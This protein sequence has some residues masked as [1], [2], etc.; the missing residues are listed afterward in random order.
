M[1]QAPSHDDS[2]VNGINLHFTVRLV[3]DVIQLSQVTST[4]EYATP[5][6]PRAAEE[7]APLLID[8]GQ[9]LSRSMKERLVGL[10]TGTALQVSGDGI[11][12]DPPHNDKKPMDFVERYSDLLAIVGYASA[13]ECVSFRF[14]GNAA[15]SEK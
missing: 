4:G 12:F 9:L 2:P 10:K 8:E 1:A 13:L 14:I 3:F 7:I 11:V 6:S 15:A 5:E